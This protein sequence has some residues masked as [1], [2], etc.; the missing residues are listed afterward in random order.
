MKTSISNK[1]FKTLQSFSSWQTIDEHETLIEFEPMGYPDGNFLHINSTHKGVDGKRR[2]SA[3]I[4][5]LTRD[6]VVMLR[7]YLDEVLAMQVS[8][9]RD[10]PVSEPSV[11]VDEER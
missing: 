7:D 1:G 9:F 8:D 4:H 6:D 10:S 2:K 11:V 3:F 5:V